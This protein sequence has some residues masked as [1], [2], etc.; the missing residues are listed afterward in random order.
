MSFISIFLQTAATFNLVCTGMIEG[1]DKGKPPHVV[2]AFTDT[3]SVNLIDRTFCFVPCMRAWPIKSVTPT[4][5]VLQDES[6]ARVTHFRK[7]NRETGA[8]Y[9]AHTMTLIYS[10]SK[11]RCEQAPFTDFPPPDRQE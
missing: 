9:A 2:R 4:E 5:I 6:E 3:I 7:V 10:R 8:Y 1:G 11:G